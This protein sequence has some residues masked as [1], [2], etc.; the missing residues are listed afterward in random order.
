MRVAEE[1]DLLRETYEQ[2]LAGY[3][4]VSSALNRHLVAGTRPSAEDLQRER[5]ARAALELAR[6]SYLDAWMLP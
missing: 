3:E 5:D 4:A 2:A 1:S 6:R